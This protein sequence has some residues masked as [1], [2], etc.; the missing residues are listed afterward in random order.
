MNGHKKV[1][2]KKRELGIARCGLACRLCGE[3][4]GCSRCDSDGGAGEAWREN[5]RRS[6]EKGA[7]G[8]YACK[9]F[10]RKDLPQ[11][12]NPYGFALFIRRY[13]LEEL[14]DC[15]ERNERQGIVYHREGL[16]GN[17]DGF[18]DAEA[19]IDFIRTGKR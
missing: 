2:T 11:K 18:E 14:M 16:V 15:L 17:Y 7:A 4:S 19:L 6:R 1:I 10:C 12:S 8:A 5:R 13:G 9:E 3:V